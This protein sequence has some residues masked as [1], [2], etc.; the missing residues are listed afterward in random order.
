MRLKPGTNLGPYEILALI[1]AGGMG[2]VYR[3]RDTRLGRDVAIKVS[4]EQFSERFE[5]EARAVAALNHPNICQIDDVGPNFIVM[6]LVEG[7]SPKGPLPL[8]TALN[9]AH[10]IAD[11]LEAAHDKNIVHRDLK[12]AN[13]KITPGGTMKVLDFGL[14]KVT[15]PEPGATSEY[16]PTLTMGATQVGMVLGTAA[17]MS[18]EQA[19]GKIVDKRAD[20]WAFGVVLFELL[21]GERPFHGN[22]VPDLLASVIKDEPKWDSIERD[23]QPLLRKC[24]AKDPKQRLRDI[25]D[26]ALLLRENANAPASGRATSRLAW[27]IA[28]LA[29]LGSVGLSITY[30]IAPRESPGMMKASLLYPDVAVPT[31][32]AVPAISPD[33]KR[34]AFVASSGGGGALGQLFVRDLDSLTARPLA[35]TTGAT[36]PFWSPD[37]K[38]IG[39]FAD[40]K[41]KR[42]DVQGAP[43][44]TLA[45][46]AFPLGGSWS[47]HDVILYRTESTGLRRV[48][49]KGGESAAVTHADSSAGTSQDGDGLPWFL[50]DGQHFLYTSTTADR[51]KATVYVADLDASDPTLSRRKV[52]DAVSNAV[53]SAGYLLFVQERTLMAQRFDLDKLQMTGDPTPLAEQINYRA[54]G[55]DCA[56]AASQNGTLV[57]SAG[58][59]ATE[60]Q[61]IWFDRSGKVVGTLGTPASQLWP[62]I[63]PDGTKV[64]IDRRDHPRTG[65]FEIWMFDLKQNSPARFTFNSDTFVNTAPVWSPDG[66]FV[67][68]SSSQSGSRDLYRK[69]LNGGREEL[70]YHDARAKTPTDWSRDGDFIIETVADPKT[71]SDLWVLPLTG[72]REPFPYLQTESVESHGKLSYVEGCRSR[73]RSIP[74]KEGPPQNMR[75]GPRRR[76]KKRRLLFLSVRE[77]THGARLP[78]TVVRSCSGSTT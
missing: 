69:A 30:R 75:I 26:A 18:P 3:A 43:P 72:D 48:P 47:N 32:Y 13:I 54:G 74:A 8:D 4:A 60:V 65:L 15:A 77:R 50:P 44:I 76:T 7:E 19:R 29:L 16:S 57:Y 25:G 36:Y 5:R 38:F 56:F 23:V 53:Y 64:V 58:D 63:S 78:S 62:A 67:V 2:E 24:L 22:D 10:Q 51:A 42:I 33:G 35:G 59:A 28:A 31:N 55:A 9:Y 66:N 14:A 46:A 20:I 27:A 1:G 11:A 40:R 73:G 21:S 45:D 49:A 37:G 71:R 12:P 6:E 61:L 34:V 52:V 41:L 17:Y 39:F 70:L 68:F